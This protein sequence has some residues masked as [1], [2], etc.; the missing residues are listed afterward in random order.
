MRNRLLQSVSLLIGMGFATAAFA[1]TAPSAALDAKDQKF[2][3]EAAIGGQFEVE[4]GRLAE[5]SA[6]PQ[7]R[8][9]GARMVKDHSAAADQLKRIVAERK[10][11]EIPQG[12]DQEHRRLLDHLASLKSPAF[13]REYMSNMVK[14]HDQDKKEFADASR[15][16]RDPQLKRFA[17]ETLPVIQQHDKMAHEVTNSMKR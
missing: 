15:D 12:L 11:A 17:Q 5:K 2:V 14:D 10:G 3:K 13:D 1:Q 9:F 16:L 4:A 6:N 8:E 7:I